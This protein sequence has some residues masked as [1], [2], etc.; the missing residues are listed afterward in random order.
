MG[1]FNTIQETIVSNFTLHEKDKANLVYFIQFLEES[2]VGQ[3]LTDI[4]NSN[5]KS[6]RGRKGYNP[7]HL[8]AMIIYGFAI[9]SGTLRK[10]EELCRCDLR[11]IFLMRGSLPT[12]VT[13]S[14]FLNNVVVK[15]YKKIF[16][17]L[18]KAFVRK[19]NLDV[20]EVF[21]DGSKFEAN[22]NKY[23]F[24]FKPTT[25][26]ARLNHSIIE[27]VNRYFPKRFKENKKF[28]T[29]REIADVITQLKA[30]IDKENYSLKTGKGIRNTPQIVKDYKLLCAQLNKC[31]EYEEKEE[32]CGENRNSYYKTDNDATAMCLKEDYYSGLGSNMHAAYNIQLI[33][34]KGIVLDFYLG[35]ERADF[36][37]F[38]TTIDEFYKNFQSYP[39]IICADSGYGSLENYEYLKKHNIQNYIKFPMWQKFVNGETIDLYK[40][41]ES[42]S[43]ICL[44]NKVAKKI[45]SN[46]HPKRKGEALYLIENC[47]FCRHKQVCFEKVK[48]KKAHQRIFKA[49]FKLWLYKQQAIKNLLSPKGIEMR[50]NRSCQVEGVFGIIKQDLAYERFRRRSLEKVSMEMSLV[51]SGFLIRKLIRAKDGDDIFT[52]WKAPHDIVDE[53]PKVKRRRKKAKSQ[54]TISIN[55]KAK[56]L[57][58]VQKRKTKR[59]L[60]I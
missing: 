17:C 2:G 12:Y 21:V 5:G 7:Y 13:I 41:D 27:L 43:L 29:S 35:Q 34:S 46:T 11:L 36:K 54:K 8:Y 55:K 15:E 23:L 25:F 39:S 40:F 1:Y 56:Q 31:L 28:V 10:L 32:I 47:K 60:G 16:T 18:V 22:A 3:I 33:V 58:K 51:L 49:N 52:F 30:K 38:P 42:E 50:V 14:E 26:H 37:A 44:N 53:K 19:F 24:V 20:S 57:Y 9:S 59:A 45:K 4:I 48:D 6:V